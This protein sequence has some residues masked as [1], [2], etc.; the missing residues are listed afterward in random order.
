MAHPRLCKACSRGRR[1]AATRALSE[2]SAQFG[3]P[4]RNPK[5]VEA[6][7]EDVPE[8]QET[9]QA[10]LRNRFHR[11]SDHYGIGGQVDDLELAALFII[12]GSVIRTGSLTDCCRLL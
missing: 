3:Q 1:T 2:A 7:G 5:Q 11:S 8:D 6:F 12:L 9:R 4:F 10:R